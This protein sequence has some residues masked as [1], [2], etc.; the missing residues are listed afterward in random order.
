MVIRFG[1]L[2][3]IAVLFSAIPNV[4]AAWGAAGHRV[5]GHVA[6][7][8]LTE[9]TRAA[10]EAILGTSDLSTVANYM[11]ER[12]AELAK[13]YP[14]SKSWH[15]N[16]RPV[17]NVEEEF[18]EYCGDGNCG[19]KKIYEYSRVLQDDQS[20]VEERAEAIR[21]IVHMVGDLHQ[22]MH[23]GDN[24]DFGGNLI[25]VKLPDGAKTKLHSA[26]D[27]NFPK[28]LIGSKSEKDYATELRARFADKAAAWQRGR[29]RTWAGESYKI[30][31]EVV[32]ANLDGFACP[33]DSPSFK[34]LD[35][36]YVI[37]ANKVIPEQLA[38]AGAR[39]AYLLNQAFDLSE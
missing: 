24:E 33:N 10:V 19:T 13:E 32:Y 21:F 31:D 37:E 38:K 2:T 6:T 15:F 9:E 22:P 20:T 39:I 17:C 30:A 14:G 5:T 28:M 23:M 1:V 35:A 27:T 16:N 11:D 29:I 34:L 25:K 18:V 26:W 8:L 12:R 4:C 36:D 3:T 7:L